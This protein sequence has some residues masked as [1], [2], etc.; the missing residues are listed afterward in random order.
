MAEENF[1]VGIIAT[2]LSCIF[3][4][5]EFLPL[6][7]YKTGDG[8]FTQL[9]MGIG[10]TFVGF[11]VLAIEGFPPIIP[12]V[13]TGGVF[14]ALGNSVALPILNH[15]GLGLGILIWNTTGCIMGWATSRFGLF[16]LSPAPPKSDLLNYLGLVFVITG[17]IFYTL[18]KTVPY[19]P[20]NNLKVTLVL[21]QTHQSETDTATVE[22][23]T[24]FSTGK[25]QMT[26][27][28]L[29]TVV[30]MISG[31][32]YSQMMTPVSYVQEHPD[33]SYTQERSA[34]IYVFSH[35][36]G[37][38]ITTVSIFIAYCILKKNNPIYDTKV[39]LPGIITGILFGLAMISLFIGNENLSQ[40]IAMPLIFTVPGCVASLWSAF[41]FKE[42]RVSFTSI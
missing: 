1:W 24:S 23:E 25:A 2:T 37:I 22:P 41:Y 11:I 7:F 12:L 4:G 21:N 32:M 36:L 33:G 8:M 40:T 6:K 18:V 10:T 28:I 38:F 19:E 30:S 35:F 5:H 29:W 20:K 42:I 15:L 34:L 27:R 17:G 31:L 9:M 3:F 16:G 13:I 26:T 39:A 14:W